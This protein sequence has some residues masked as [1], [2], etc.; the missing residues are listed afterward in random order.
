MP[1][2]RIERTVVAVRRAAVESPSGPYPI[3]DSVYN[4]GGAAAGAGYRQY[5]GDRT[6]LNFRGLYSIKHYASVEGSVV[7]RGHQDDRLDLGATASFVDATEVGFY[8]LGP[9]NDESDR[10]N[11]RQRHTVAGGQATWRARWPLVLGAGL[12]AEFFEIDS[13]HG[14]EPSVERE[15]TTPRRR[16]AS[17]CRPATPTRTSR[18]RSTGARRP[19]TPG[20]A[21][22]TG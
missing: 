11:F 22:C 1:P 5:V 21:G 19:A 7:S 15:S 13:G 17:G 9:E 6:Y 3:L 20:A 8:G 2:G 14:D 18:R 10:A 16:R 12:A 4:G